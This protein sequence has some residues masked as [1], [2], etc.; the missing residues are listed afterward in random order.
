M[1]LEKGNLV[2]VRRVGD[3]EW[4]TGTVELASAITDFSKPIQSL[5]IALDGPVR[6]GD[7]LILHYLPL[8][9]DYAKE[10]TWGLTGEDYE[11]EH[12]DAD[13]TGS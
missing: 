5:A 1:I 7:G 3:E 10:R 9:C 8:M 2:R 13:S 4:T 12:A 6:A 11:V